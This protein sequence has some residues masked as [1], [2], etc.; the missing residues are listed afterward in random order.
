MPDDPYTF[1]I[2]LPGVTLSHYDNHMVRRLSA[3]KGQFGDHQAFEQLLQQDDRVLYEVY[4]LR[5]PEVAG[6]LLHGL[7]VVHLL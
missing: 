4:E 2:D 5:R 3:M 6:E 7:S 1:E